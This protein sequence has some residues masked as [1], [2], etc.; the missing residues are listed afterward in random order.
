MMVRLLTLV[1]EGIEAGEL[2]GGTGGRLA[3]PLSFSSSCGILSVGLQTFT[4]KWVGKL[5][6]HVSVSLQKS[7]GFGSWHLYRMRMLRSLRKRLTSHSLPAPPHSH[8]LFPADAVS[9]TPASCTQLS[10]SSSP[11]QR[12]LLLLLQPLRLQKLR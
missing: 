5:V 4:R 9:S 7:L 10:L 12:E 2:G 1:S 3:M 6:E 11:P 8:Q